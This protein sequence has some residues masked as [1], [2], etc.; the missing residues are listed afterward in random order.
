MMRNLLPALLLLLGT[1]SPLWAQTITASARPEL[2]VTVVVPLNGDH[3]IHNWS[4]D[5]KGHHR[6]YL[7]R[8]I[9]Q[10]LCPPKNLM[11]QRRLILT[12]S[13]VMQASL[14]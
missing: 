4:S 9:S 14:T 11:K 3:A 13:E 8:C 2:L 12:G 1:A 5:K 10:N 6:D 7:W